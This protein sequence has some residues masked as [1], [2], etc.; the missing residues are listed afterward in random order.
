MKQRTFTIQNKLGI[1]MKPAGLLV[2][3]AGKYK[4][5]ISVYKDNM[6]HR[7]VNAKSLI[8]VLTLAAGKGSTVTVLADGE[9]EEQALNGL[10]D[11]IVRRKFDEE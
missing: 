1:H 7:K 10:E 5:K 11:L 4:S 6:E 8:G 2:R 3:E 9:D